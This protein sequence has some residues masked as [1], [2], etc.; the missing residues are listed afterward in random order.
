MKLR[1]GQSEVKCYTIHQ[2]KLKF[3]SGKE[4]V[5]EKL[6][7]KTMQSADN[8]MRLR[9]K[10]YIMEKPMLPE[11]VILLG[12]LKQYCKLAFT[13]SNFIEN[14]ANGKQQLAHIIA[15]ISK[16]SDRRLTYSEIVSG[17]DELELAHAKAN[18]YNVIYKQDMN[19]LPAG[20]PD[21]VQALIDIYT[22]ENSFLSKNKIASVKGF[23]AGN[24]VLKQILGGV[25]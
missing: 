14:E 10:E 8:L 7:R 13:G 11:N 9:Q 2:G 5:N 24:E 3:V 21:K 12:H 19:A 18:N 4:L 25:K 22:N 1:Y 15:F 6:A 16:N 23:A 17:A 20:T